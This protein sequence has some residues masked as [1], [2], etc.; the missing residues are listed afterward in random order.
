MIR[1]RLLATENSGGVRRGEIGVGSGIM[2]DSIVTGEYTE[3]KL[4]AT[5]LTGLR[6]DFSLFETIYTTKREGCR[7]LAL[8]LARLQ[9]S[10]NYFGF[11]FDP[12]PVPARLQERYSNFSG[13]GAHRLRLS[14]SADGTIALSSAPLSPLV[15]PVKIL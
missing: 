2:Y 7:H 12:A 1:T 4:K 15:Q 10:A 5:F 8:H 9:L 11:V 6:D 3:C 14:L 13:N